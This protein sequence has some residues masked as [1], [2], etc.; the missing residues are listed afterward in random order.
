MSLFTWCAQRAGGLSMIVLIALCY[1]VISRESTTEQHRYKYEQPNNQGT[2]YSSTSTTGAGIWTYLFS[3]YCLLI[4]VLVCVFPLRAC[5]TVWTLTQSLKRAA[6]SHSLLDLKKLASRRDSYTS[7]S[8]SETLISSHN[9]GCSSTTSEAGDIDPE[10]Y[11]DGVSGAGDN[12][13][14]A[15]VIPNYKEEHDTLKETLEVLASHPQAQ[16]SYDVYLGMEQR[17]ANAET[18]ALGLIQEFAKKF[19]SIDFTLHPSDI[20]AEA[21]GKGSNIGWAARKLSEKY[22]MGVRR[23]VIITGID[24]DSHLSSSYFTILTNMHLSYPE[25]ALTTVYSAPVIFDRN[26]HAVPALVRVAD[27]LWCAAGMSGLYPGSTISPPTSVY[28][29]PLDLVDRVGGWD[30]GSEAIGEDLHMYIKCFF[31]LNGNLTSRV[32]HS[33]VSQSN[34]TGGGS[35]LGDVRAR[36]KQALRH[37][38]GALDTGFALRRLVEMWQD[39]KQTS[40]TYQPLHCTFADANSLAIH[41][42]QLGS[43]GN[44]QPCENGIFSDITK[45]TIKEPHWEHVFYMMHRLFEA[46]FLPVHMAVLVLASTIY[47][48]LTEGNE[49]PHDLAWV[50]SWCNVIRI[51]GFFQISIYVFLY[52]SFHRVGVA[53]RE[54]EMVKA[55]LASEM[56]FSRRSLGKNWVDYLVIPVVAPLYGTIPSAQALICQ[57][58]AQDLV[59]TVSKKATRRQIPVVRVDE[60]A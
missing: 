37:M 30:C 40:R 27:I 53:S 42:S 14:H 18:K 36:Y 46:H 49:D 20:P 19:R 16:D 59:Y 39:R 22:S 5:W 26:A 43:E 35:T 29:L 60:M 21:A 56:D 7:V 31:T 47:V 41:E 48:K 52:E 50:F 54:R 2:Y 38:W 12:V 10:L 55:G 51:F 58:W 15:I 8:S 45:D 57:L 23:N 1:W 13:I 44:G 28:S 17:E 24:A 34:V 33:P 4:H 32:I 6:Q 3:Y 25:T 11:T 9:G